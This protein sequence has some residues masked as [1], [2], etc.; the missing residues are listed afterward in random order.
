MGYRSAPGAVCS[1]RSVMLRPGPGPS[2]PAVGA[3]TRL[4]VLVEHHAAVRRERQ[5]LL[6]DWREAIPSPQLNFPLGCRDCLSM[7]FPGFL[8]TPV[9]LR[10]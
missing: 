3:I 5:V 4:L 6:G 8:L 7:V 10:E 2:A 9:S 1:C